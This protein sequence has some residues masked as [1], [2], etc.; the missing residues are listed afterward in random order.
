MKIY[1]GIGARKTPS[2]MIAQMKDIGHML[3]NNGWTLRSGAADGAD[4]AF[5]KGCD[6]VGDDKEI[7][8]PWEGFNNHTST[9]Y[10]LSN[11]A[12]EIAEEV[13]PAWSKLSQAAQKLMARNVHQLIGVPVKID[14]QLKHI[15]SDVVVCWTPDGAETAKETTAATGGTGQAIR[16]ASHLDIPVFNLQR[17]KRLHQ[18]L[19]FVYEVDE[20]LK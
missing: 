2:H 15:L 17:P 1:T 19:E 18:L 9:L 5:E 11:Y 7:F 10:A 16:I 12:F 20:E 3:A 4:T 8:L 14:D 13:H 6:D